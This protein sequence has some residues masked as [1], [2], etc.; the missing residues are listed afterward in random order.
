MEV[1]CGEQ[2]QGTGGNEEARVGRRFAVRSA[3][4]D[5]LPS[6]INSYGL[7]DVCNYGSIDGRSEHHQR[8]QH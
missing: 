8:H 3:I 1:R 7:Y 6:A 4:R 5:D 2:P